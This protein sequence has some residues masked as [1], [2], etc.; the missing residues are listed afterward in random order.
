M[1][2]ILNAPLQHLVTQ[3][4]HEHNKNPAQKYRTFVKHYLPGGIRNMYIRPL[5]NDCRV[6]RRKN[7]SDVDQTV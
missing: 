6:R 7:L 5:T 4:A 1:S 3:Y 2:D